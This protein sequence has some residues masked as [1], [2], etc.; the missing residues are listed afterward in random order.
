MEIKGEPENPKMS[1]C[2]WGA[3]AVSLTGEG[4]GACGRQRPWTLSFG[5]K[6]L[7]RLGK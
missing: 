4:Q 6:I 2:I 5:D 7:R 3:L 1:L